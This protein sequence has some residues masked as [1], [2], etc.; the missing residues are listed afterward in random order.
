MLAGALRTRSRNHD[1]EERPMTDQSH[2]RARAGTVRI[3]GNLATIVFVRVLRHAPEVVWRAITDPV[4]LKRWLMCSSATI[5]GRT[6]GRIAMV[7]GPAQFQVSGAILA[8]DPPRIYEHEW[9]VAPGPH[10]PVGEN[11]IFRYELVPRGE[12]TQLTVTYRRLTAATARGF[13]PGTHLLLDRLEAQLG[14]DVLPGWMPR[15]DELRALY[16]AWSA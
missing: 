11:A 1:H 14:K 7:S 13:A 2:D 3:D 15:F 8:W 16:P 4:E 5:D 6:G 9:T 12:Q 10:M